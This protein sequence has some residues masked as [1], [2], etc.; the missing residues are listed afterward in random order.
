M[1]DGSKHR[2]SPLVCAA[3][4]RPSIKRSKKQPTPQELGAAQQQPPASNDPA[5]APIAKPKK[6]RKAKQAKAPKQS[7][8]SKAPRRASRSAGGI[9]RVLGAPFRKLAGLTGRARVIAWGLIVVLVIVLAL[10]LRGGP[11]DEQDVRAALTRFEQAS[12]DK[13]YQTLCDDLLASSYVRQ[14]ASSGLPCEVALRTGLEDVKNPTLT[15]VSVEVNGDRA[16]ARVRGRA[17][18]QVPAEDVYTL[19]REGDEWRILPPR[20]EAAR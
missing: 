19:I 2:P 3:V 15:I 12:A 5:F 16:A 20:P 1:H 14:T 13:D 10:V 6:E 11:D 17:A 18:G 7:K 8:Q 9:G 4:K